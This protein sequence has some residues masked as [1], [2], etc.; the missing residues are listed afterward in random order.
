MMNL[1]VREQ[2]AGLASKYGQ[3]IVR[4]IGA[5]ADDADAIWKTEISKLQ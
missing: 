4:D 2:V 3:D 1:E 5:I